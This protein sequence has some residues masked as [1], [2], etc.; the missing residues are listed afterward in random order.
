MATS[1]QSPRDW[2]RQK[3]IEMERRYREL[4]RRLDEQRRREQGAKLR[5]RNG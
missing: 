2:A 4:Q 3:Q 5:R 1:T